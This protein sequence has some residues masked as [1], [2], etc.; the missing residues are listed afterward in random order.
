VNLTSSG[1]ASTWPDVNQRN[2]QWLAAVSLV[3]GMLGAIVAGVLD[4]VAWRWSLFWWGAAIGAVGI[5]HNEFVTRLGV[6]VNAV[7]RERRIRVAGHR[8]SYPLMWLALGLLIG[9][10]SA[11]WDIVWIDVAAGAYAAVVWLLA[12]VVLFFVYRRASSTVDE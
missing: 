2:L 12:S 3:A 11:A 8:L 7:P 4:P 6:R 10:L 5:A 1:R 9:G